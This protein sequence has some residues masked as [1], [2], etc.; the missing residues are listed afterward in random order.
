MRQS[1]QTKYINPTN[2]RGARIAATSASGRR[3]VISWDDAADTDTNH[4][5][6]AAR[7]AEKL[8]W[9]GV[10]ACGS[11]PHGCVFVLQDGDVIGIRPQRAG[12]AA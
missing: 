6:A 9:H 10:W 12:G 5:I 2:T 4:K 7:L 8:N 11:I 3:I 1:I